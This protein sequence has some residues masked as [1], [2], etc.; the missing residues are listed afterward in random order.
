MIKIQR[1]FNFMMRFLANICIF[2]SLRMCFLRTSGIN[3]G[4][5]TFINMGVQFIDNYLGKGKITIG[6]RVS[7]ASNTIF[8]ADADP[9]N[10]VL[11]KIESF[12]KR[13]NLI[14]DDDAWIGAGAIILPNIHIGK[15]SVIGAGSI[16]T[17]DVPDFF[18]VAGNP[19]RK[20]GIIKEEEICE[21]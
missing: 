12:V 19:A 15:A 6:D 11:R 14:I 7:I 4:K 8:I 17:K 9:N 16:V 20:I 10:S 13:G 3:I 2:P 1:F 18:I 5:N 21:K